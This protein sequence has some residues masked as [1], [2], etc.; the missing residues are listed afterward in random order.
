[1][2]DTNVCSCGVELHLGCMFAGMLE[3]GVANP[4]PVLIRLATSLQT[5]AIGSLAAAAAFLI[6]RAIS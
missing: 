5:L 4:L 3:S 6:A 2:A 1:M